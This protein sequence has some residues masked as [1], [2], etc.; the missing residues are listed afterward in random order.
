ML[1]PE[2][3]AGRDG[4]M[5]SIAAFCLQNPAVPAAGTDEPMGRSIPV[6]HRSAADIL[7]RHGGAQAAHERGFAFYRDQTERSHGGWFTAGNLLTMLFRLT[8]HEELQRRASI[9]VAAYV[10]E[11]EQPFP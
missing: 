10:L 5:E 1:Y 2:D 3:S 8:R 4:Y 7:A 9:N 6:N 11:N